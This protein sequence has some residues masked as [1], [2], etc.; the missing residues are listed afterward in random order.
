[1]AGHSR[2]LSNSADGEKLRGYKCFQS[3][4]LSNLPGMVYRCRN[5]VDW[6][7]EYVSDGCYELTGYAPDDLIG[8]RSIS[9][10]QI[11]HP[12]DRKMVRDEVR[13]ALEHNEPYTI[14]Y[15]IITAG[16]EEKWVWEQGQLAPGGTG[17]EASLEGFI[18][19]TTGQK[20]ANEALRKSEAK[21]ESIFRSAPT[22][23]GVVV[24]RIITEA[25]ERLCEMTGYRREELID[26]S[27]CI[28]Y[29]SREE[30]ERAG[31]VKYDLIEKL[32]HGSV[33]TR[34]RRK[35]GRVIDVLLSSSPIDHDNIQAGVTF[36]ALDITESKAA[37]DALRKS[38]AK[39]R[40]VA[41]NTYDWEF[42]LSPDLKFIYSSPSCERITGYTAEEFVANPHLLCDIIHPDD[43][44]SFL[45]HQRAEV[46]HG[47]LEFRVYTRDGEMRWLHHTCMPVFDAEG[48]FMG[49][50]G[51]NR[52][53]TGRKRAEE[54]LSRLASIVM[55]SDDAILS[56]RLDGT[57][58][59]WNRGAE[60]LYG[61][62][63]AEAVGRPIDII[64]PR[65]RSAEIR[66]ILEK[67][68]RGE[69]IEHYETER[70]TRD[71]HKI[72]VSITISPIADINGEIIGASTIARDI[73]ENKRAEKALKKSQ[74][75]LAKSQEMAHVGNWAWNVRTNEINCSDEGFRI[76]GCPLQEL[77]PT[78]EWLM[79]HVHPGDATAVAARYEKIRHEGW[80]GSFDYRIV[81]PDGSIRYVNTVADKI[82]RDRAGRMKWVYG[83]TQD[84]TVRKQSEIAMEDARARSELYLDLMGHDINN[85]NQIALGYLEV[86]LLEPG[87]GDRQREMLSKSLEAVMASS[88]LIE[89]VRKLQQASSDRKGYIKTD[90]GELLRRAQSTFSKVPGTKAT[91][92]YTEATPGGCTVMAD[93]LLYDVF[94]NIVGNA[95]KHGGS[96]PVVDIRLDGVQI[97]GKTYCRVAVEDDGP[98]IPD[99][100]KEKVFERQRRG[101][102]KAKGSGLGLYLVRTLVESYSGYVR[103]EDRVPGDPGKGAKFMVLLPV[104]PKC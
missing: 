12:D 23:I 77:Q 38:E 102:T 21:L 62:T 88:R 79:S 98:G 9:Y 85:M 72:V 68:K 75:I 41:E 52:D 14:T 11:I 80:L 104:A 43:R 81:R 60:R 90:V 17:G 59:S 101:D 2:S 95:V 87:L 28:L 94:A 45:T 49:N 6:T 32:G 20:R 91:I 24:N 73:T 33:E 31:R 39:Y 25:N 48:Q 99:D 29:T 84:I 96:E 8:N 76:F 64:V 89:N 5:D 51:S 83:I 47:D 82:V 10:N 57:I 55:S 13:R 19:D 42:W 7:M 50:R 67:V 93:G 54:E 30:Y 58:I 69:R 63:A 66:D 97:D 103:A 92:R 34:W 61:Y 40:I 4:L 86:T 3:T 26:R 74:F 36:T 37:E 71:G 1:M 18:T 27:A 78:F 16:G 15:R 44:P 70:I 22:G 53:I 46:R 65:E 56:K 35:D 100:M